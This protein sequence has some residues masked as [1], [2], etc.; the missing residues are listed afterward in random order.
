M[1]V[2]AGGFL[3]E[4]GQHPSEAPLLAFSVAACCA[5]KPPGTGAGRR[6]R[7]AR[8]RGTPS[9]GSCSCRALAQGSSSG[10]PEKRTWIRAPGSAQLDPRSWSAKPR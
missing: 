6:G 1:A 10:S 2:V 8:Q 7:R 9:P 5:R 3:D 4:V